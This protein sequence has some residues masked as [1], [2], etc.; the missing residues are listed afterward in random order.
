MPISA[1]IKRICVQDQWFAFRSYRVTQFQCGRQN[2]V[3]QKCISVEKNLNPY[4]TLCKHFKQTILLTDLKNDMVNLLYVALQFL[5][6]ICNQKKHGVC[7]PNYKEYHGFSRF[8]LHCFP[9]L[10]GIMLFLLKNWAHITHSK[11]YINCLTM[12]IDAEIGGRKK[13]NRAPSRS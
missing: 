11:M 5:L 7:L 6:I 13:R 12:V 10:I 3:T 4:V 9:I 2:E 1:I 8:F